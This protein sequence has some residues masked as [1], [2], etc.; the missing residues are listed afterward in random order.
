L[1][2]EHVSSS[3]LPRPGPASGAAPPPEPGLRGI[4]EIATGYQRAQV[5]LAAS[6]LGLF[7]LLARGPCSVPDVARGLQAD[8]RGVECLLRACGALGLVRESPEGWRNSRTAALFLVPGR[9]GSFGPVLRF[10]RLWSYGPWGRISEAVRSGTPQTASGPKSADLFEDLLADREQSGVFF[11]GLA[12]LAYWPARRLAELVDL[13]SRRRLVDVGGGAGAIAE[14]LALRFPELRVT[15]FDLPAVCELA[16]ERFARSPAAARL[17]TVAGDFHRDSLPACDSLFLG[18]VL[19]DWSEAEDVALLRKAHAALEPGGTLIV[20]DFLP[21]RG[22]LAIEPALFAL[23]LL[24]DTERG[25][26]YTAD[27]VRGW[28]E[29]T[30]FAAVGLEAVQAGLSVMTAKKTK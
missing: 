2:G 16:R 30:G 15:L 26:V 19:H 22:D 21:A 5:L 3:L 25:T 17:T 23:S 13:K 7:D 24:L 29:Q 9:E 4:V 10:W 11:D 1:I 18:N 28:L 20:Y 14:A 8:H 12:G 6:D 27:R